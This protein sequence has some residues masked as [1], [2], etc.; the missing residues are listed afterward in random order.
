MSDDNIFEKRRAMYDL[1]EAITVFRDIYPAMPISF[2][3]VF[4]AGDQ[5][6]CLY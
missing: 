1:A 2:V 5:Y 4:L 3:A 6:V